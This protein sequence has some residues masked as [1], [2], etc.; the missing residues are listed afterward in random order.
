MIPHKIALVFD[1]IMNTKSLITCVFYDFY[2]PV[3]SEE[4]ILKSI[5]SHR[6][7]KGNIKPPKFIGG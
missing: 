5:K 3:P 6:F 4:F 1:V 7:D 2:H